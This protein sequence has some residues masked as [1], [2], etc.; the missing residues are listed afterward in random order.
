MPLHNSCSGHCPYG[1]LTQEG[2]SVCSVS[3][4]MVLYHVRACLQRDLA[5]WAGSPQEHISCAMQCQ[6]VSNQWDGILSSQNAHPLLVPCGKWKN[7]HCAISVV[8]LHTCMQQNASHLLTGNP[9]PTQVMGW[10][11]WFDD[12]YKQY[13][14]LLP[15]IQL[16]YFGIQ[17]VDCTPSLL[18]QSSG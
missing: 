2:P 1:C 13:T 12:V 6:R 7:P 3:Q 4:E 17:R 16:R 15:G 5:T 11:L 18:P 8:T 10:L 14:A 9:F